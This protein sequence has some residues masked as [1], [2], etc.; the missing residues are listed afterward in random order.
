MDNISS[1]GDNDN[2][3]EFAALFVNG[4]GNSDYSE[5]VKMAKGYKNDSGIESVSY[6]A[7]K[8]HVCTRKEKFSAS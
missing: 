4:T 7:S 5:L 8:L 6:E 3:S 2:A 1:T